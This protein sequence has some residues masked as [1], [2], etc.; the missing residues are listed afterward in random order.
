M[1][2]RLLYN[3]RS[4]PL[5]VRRENAL[6]T[7]E[8][9]TSIQPGLRSDRNKWDAPSDSKADRTE[10]S[11]RTLTRSQEEERSE[12]TRVSRVVPRSAGSLNSSPPATRVRDLQTRPR[13]YG[14]R[15][16][17]FIQLSSFTWG[18]KSPRWEVS[19]WEKAELR[20][21]AEVKPGAL[22]MINRLQSL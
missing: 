3:Q 4:C 18:R 2:H 1:K 21:D 12:L 8:A 13:V 5:V 10:H 14:G 22:G 9:R 11:R 15:P 17:P 19:P 20:G 16:G 7:H 6:L